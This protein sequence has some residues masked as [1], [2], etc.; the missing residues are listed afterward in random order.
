MKTFS[1]NTSPPPR[2]G[3]FWLALL[4]A[5]ILVLPGLAQSEDPDDDR[6]VIRVAG[7]AAPPPDATPDE[8]DSALPFAR[9]RFQEG[10]LRVV[11]QDGYEED[12]NT[13]SP[14]FA[15]DRVF[16]PGD[17][18][19]EIQLPDGSVVRLDR[20]TELEI[21]DLGGDG[22]NFD[23]PS[24]LALRSG[25]VQVDAGGPQALR[26]DTSA[27]AVYPLETSAFRIDAEPGGPVRVTVERGRVEV[28]G[29]ERSVEVF[30]G[31][32]T[33]VQAGQNPRPAWRVNLF[34]RDRFD[35]WV[36]ER[37]DIFRL[38]GARSEAYRQMPDEVRPYYGELSSYGD[39][40]YT[41]TYGWV[42]SPRGVED[43][44]R[45]YWN[46]Y[47][48]PGPYG[49][50]WVGYEPWGWS[51]YRYG[52]WSFQLGLGWVWA[53]GRY[54]AP[55]HVY[56]YYGPDSM[57][58]SPLDYWNRPA[59]FSLSFNWGHS[60]F[61]HHCW[62]FSH[63]H[64]FYYHPVRPRHVIRPP[65][66]RGVVSRRAIIPAREG[67]ETPAL[68]R[69]RERIARGVDPGT[70]D[71][72]RA[73]AR[74]K[75]R[76]ERENLEKAKPAPKYVFRDQEK[77][78]IERRRAKQREKTA[79]TGTSAPENTRF[80]PKFATPGEGPKHRPAPRREEAEAPEKRKD[81][82]APRPLPRT[83]EER[84][85]S[86]PAA[87]EDRGGARGRPPARTA[88]P[89]VRREPAGGEE[90]S[91]RFPRRNSAS[92]AGPAQQPSSGFT[93]RPPAQDQA[94]R[95]GQEEEPLRRFMGR[96]SGSDRS[97]EAGNRPSRK[98]EQ[99]AAPPSPPPSRRPPEARPQPSR[100]EKQDRPERPSVKPDR[101]QRPSPPP[102]RPAPESSRPSRGDDG[103]SRKPKSKHD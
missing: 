5:G 33:Q 63:Y 79:A 96:L 92:D 99:Q 76:I 36:A 44:W 94:P 81:N 67:R 6:S 37:D 7:V 77:Q 45:P 29:E 58:W 48:S 11:R 54:F 64:D 15:G 93:R 75:P 31:Q 82:P 8:D 13:N 23:R 27:A 50:V 57:G 61:D 22:R 39:W 43:D 1:P 85:P 89:P 32:R 4:A 91:I 24:V 102:S 21:Y 73:L 51:V 17:N 86:P 55:A 30:T 95:A 25:S 10:G 49:P 65:L 68:R 98:P 53:P 84:R 78:V 90:S 71:R 2:G 97:G 38:R 101:P 100:P 35:D 26:I 9:V 69:G 80:K 41:E 87:G 42:W 12:L 88:S 70:F 34:N 83:P 47:W 52:R 3:L 103:G 66:N 14:V 18:R 40:V 72:A 59:F 46:G 74:E 16:S 60:W 56:W 20:S 62:A 19:A 28:A